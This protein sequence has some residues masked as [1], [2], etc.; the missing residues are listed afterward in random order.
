MDGRAGFGRCVRALLLGLALL[1]AIGAR[2]EQQNLR[3]LIDSSDSVVQGTAELKLADNLEMLVQLLPEG[4]QAGVW[5]F[6]GDVFEFMAPQTVDAAWRDAVQRALSNLD[7]SGDNSDIPAAIATATEDLSANPTSA[8]TS[9]VLLTDGKLAV[10]SSPMTN[11]NAS[12]KLLTDRA[13]ELADRGIP[14]HTIALTDD[15]DRNFLAALSRET[16]GVSLRA[17]SSSELARSLLQLLQTVSPAL[18]APLTGGEFVVGPGVSSFRAIVFHRARAGRLG[19]ESPGGQTF[20]AGDGVDSASWFFNESVALVSVSD[21]EPGVWRLRAPRLEGAQVRLRGELDVELTLPA[22]AVAGGESV[23]L[24][25]QLQDSKGVV[26][27]DEVL[28]GLS[29]SVLVRDPAGEVTPFDVALTE[30][31]DPSGPLLFT[32]PTM[33]TAGRYEITARIRDGDEWI[34]DYPVYLDVVAMDSRQSISTRVEDITPEGLEGPVISLGVLILV[35]LAVLLRVLKRR[36]ERK[37]KLWQERFADPE[38]KGDSGLFP[39]I[40]MQTGEHS[41]PP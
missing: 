22:D 23:Q 12:R 8:G 25:L 15:A 21:P 10:S 1:A 5:V 41:K 38:G 16:G 11:A 33:A 35:A 30:K 28:S 19:L 14:V 34:Y 27:T 6:G 32:L 20:R 17:R 18:Q 3:I 37:L 39:G 2:A 4:S 26:L 13:A 7:A 36:R 9:L 40:R 24:A 29:L 31:A